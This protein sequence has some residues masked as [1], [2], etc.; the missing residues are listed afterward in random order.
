MII[1]ITAFSY[2]ILLLL[3]FYIVIISYRILFLLSFYDFISYSFVTV[4]NEKHKLMRY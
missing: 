4:S 3:S 1:S 2:R